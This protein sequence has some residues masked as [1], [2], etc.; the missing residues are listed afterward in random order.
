MLLSMHTMN[1]RNPLVWILGQLLLDVIRLLMLGGHS[2]AALKAEN[3]FLGKQLTLYLERKVKPRRADPAT[4]LT[5]V[6]LSRLFA[7]RNALTIVK[8]ETLVR[9]QRKAF[10][11]FWRGKSKPPGRPPVPAGLRNLIAEMAGSHPTWGEERIAAEL[12]LKLGIR[13]SP[14]TIRRYLPDHTGPRRGLSSQRWMT[15]VRNHAQAVVACDFFVAVTATFRVL[16]V[17]V[18][19]EVG[20]RRIAHFNVTAHPTP[21][22]T[23]QQFREVMTGEQGHQFVIHDRDSI[24]SSELDATLRSMGLSIL[25]TPFR[26][27]QA[28]AFCE[29]LVGT[30]RRECLDFLLPLSESHLRGI[31]KEWVAY[32]NRSRPHS[33][34]GPGMPDPPMDLP[35]EGSPRH[36]VPH[37]RR[38]VAK[39]VLGG[40][41]HEYRLEQVAA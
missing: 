39:P 24:H 28:N 10:R 23:L 19:M 29:R 17:F 3:L 2:K 41:H 15:F 32:Y 9:W 30:L 6:L 14:R 8:P 22:W 12:L 1:A 35:G 13:V 37:D 27:P 4:R 7:W 34:L 20:T 26:S 31:L 16:Y 40:L 38:I 33:S 5:L 36:C 21:S 11:L 18:I 25:K